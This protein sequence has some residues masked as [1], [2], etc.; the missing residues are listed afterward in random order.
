MAYAPSN[1][2]IDHVNAYSNGRTEFGRFLSNFAHTPFTCPDGHFES[3]EGYWHW[4][5][6]PESCPERDEL[7]HV[8][9]LDA[10]RLGRRLRD[11]YGTV[12]CPD[13]ERRIRGAVRCKL[14][15][16]MTML[17]K[18]EAA[19]PI[20]HYYVRGG[21]AQNAGFEWLVEVWNQEVADLRARL[22]A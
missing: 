6:T 1:D 3:V 12:T 7:R 11:T 4:L 9:G 2:G 21:R 16:R 22:S 15:T 10:K 20:A 14:M 19:L 13:F 18:P 17:L 8:W 5:G